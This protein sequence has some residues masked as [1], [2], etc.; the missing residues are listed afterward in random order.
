MRFLHSSIAAL[1][2]VGL[3]WILVVAMAG[4][5]SGPKTR[6]DRDPATDLSAY[7]TFGFYDQSAGASRYTTIM[8]ARLERATREQLERLGYVHDAESPDLRVNFRLNI[9]ER[10]EVRST[11][12]TGVR[13][14][15][16][17]GWAGYSGIE[18]VNY[19]QG[20]LVID[21]VDAA[22]SALVW[23]GVAEGRLDGK[24]TKNPGAAVDATVRELFTG[25]PGGV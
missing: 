12:A 20:T 16:Y 17:G 5:A 11:P 23:R 14:V 1:L 6:V 15:F 3:T 25:F 18:T 8:S 22:R 24:V 19:R 4:C 10:Q 7:R 2:S 9:V 13:P 21:L